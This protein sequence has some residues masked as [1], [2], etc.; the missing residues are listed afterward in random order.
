MAD[1]SSSY[2]I[3]PLDG[4]ATY[5]TWSI[6]LMDILTEAGLYEYVF[7]SKTYRPVLAPQRTVTIPGNTPDAPTT[8]QTIPAVTEADIEDWETKQRKALSTIRLRV[9]DAPMVYV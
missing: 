9:G 8:T 4:A 1:S 5:P 2:K 6:K 7:G 3:K